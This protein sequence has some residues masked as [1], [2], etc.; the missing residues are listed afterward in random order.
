MLPYQET[1]KDPR[2]EGGDEAQS[3]ETMPVGSSL[4]AEVQLPPRQT[5]DF[6]D[7]ESGMAFQ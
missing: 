2:L 6:C 3:D 4:L 5:V 1:G 7:T